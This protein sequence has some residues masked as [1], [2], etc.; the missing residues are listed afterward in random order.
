MK[1]IQKIGF[2]IF[3]ISFAIF[4]SLL[5]VGK[6][7]LTDT[8]FNNVIT[9]KTHQKLLKPEL[10]NILDKEY[11]SNIDFI[12]DFKNSVNRINEKFKSEQQWDKLIYTDYTLEIV[13][14]STIGLVKDNKTLFFY[15]CF[16]VSALGG[17][18]YIVAEL[19]ISP[20]AGIKNNNIYKTRITSRGVI[21]FLF[22]AFLISFYIFLYK[23][24]A[25]LSNWIL[26][27]DDLSLV[28]TGGVASQWFLYGFLYSLIMTTMGIKMYVKY[29]HSNYQLLRTTSVIFF[30]L[31]F[32]F[33]IPNILI[34]LQMP[35]MDF[36]NMWPLDYSFF[37]DYRLDELTAAG[38]LGY[39]M[40]GWGIFLFVVG[41]PV[42]VYFFGKRWY[43]SWVCGCGGLAET[44]GDPFR[45]LSDKSLKAWKYER[46]I[47]HSVLV[48]VIVMTIAVLYTFFTGTTT[49]LGI[50]TY[51][52]REVY[53]F[54]IGFVF[55]GA[56][57]TGFYPLM[58]NR[59]WC[60]FGCPLA[61]YLG[62]VQRFKS[63]FRI[64]TNGGQCISCGNCS[65]YCEMGIDVRA[66]AQKGENIIRAS[67]VGCGIC[68]AVC[69][70]GVLKLENLAEEGRFDAYI[71][72]EE[73]IIK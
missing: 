34:K 42:M 72:P 66:Y 19:F 4:L 17:L 29:R 56:I 15:I 73:S 32:A 8:V 46:V 1:I 11:T 70:R 13:K 49:I 12:K 60:R 6:Y 54:A 37:F 33:I 38:T 36:K 9:D 31:A 51:L 45:Q 59:V 63:R 65:T 41:V 50:D 26:L 35:S 21:A 64:T 14:Q 2:G 18:I 22:A 48:F 43:C 7:K 62:L 24:P 39:W 71:R 68:A 5:F 53:A 57:G 16:V 52:I 67:C 20:V 58:G 3:L 25:Y 69:P 27:V 55:A 28:L 47:V 10:S 61:A 30:Q 23:A 44:L 40:L